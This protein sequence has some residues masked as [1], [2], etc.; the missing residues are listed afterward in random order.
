MLA[1][2]QETLKKINS[3]ITTI[4]IMSLLVTFFVVISFYICLYLEISGNNK[5]LIYKESNDI[6]G[7]G[8]NEKSTIFASI[9]GTTYTFSWC[10]GANKI[11]EENKIFFSNEKEA[12]N[13]GRR[14]SKMCNR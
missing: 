5:P 11:K 4:Q 7:A 12:I 9:N 13:S 10:Q 2:I 14:L 1:I 6:T 8:V 3:K